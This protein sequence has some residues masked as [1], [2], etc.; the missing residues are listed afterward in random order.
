MYLFLLFTVAFPSLSWA[1]AESLYVRPSATCTNNGD[2]TA[3]ACADS[4]GAA[5]A[6]RGFASVISN[7]IDETAGSLDPGDTLFAC[8][9]FLAADRDTPNYHFFFNVS[10]SY[11]K[12]VTL[13]G[14]CSAVGG[15]ISATLDGETTTLY[16]IGTDA[17]TYLTITH[18]TLT[19]FTARGLLLYNNATTD[20]ML[21]KY[22]TLDRLTIKNIRGASAICSDSRGQHLTFTYVTVTGCGTD[23]I[24]H[25]GADLIVYHATISRI[26]LDA[27]NN[28]D[29]IQLSGILNGALISDSS[30]DMTSMDSK[31][32]L[33]SQPT[34]TG[35]MYFTKNTCVR[36][37]TDTVGSGIRIECPVNMGCYMTC[38]DITGGELGL[39]LINAGG[40]I[41]AAGNLIRGN[42]HD[43]I[44]SGGTGSGVT[45]IV[46]NICDAFLR[47]GILQSNAS[48]TA[49]IENN[50]VYGG[51]ACIDKQA[52]NTEQYNLLYGCA[53]AVTNN[54]T[55]T[56]IGTGDV[57]TQYGS[58]MPFKS[59]ATGRGLPPAVVPFGVTRGSASRDAATNRAVRP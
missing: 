37:T 39:H 34:D 32:C 8:G 53:N 48:V 43:C 41:L 12:I 27:A 45:F 38:S 16:G 9:S 19:G 47:D 23:G 7:A 58:V 55:P 29:G 54:G 2:G 18:L 4:P 56:T 26:S 17:H 11:G 42:T 59:T 52:A 24:W 40:T 10:G 5:G 33:I 3:Y 22:L 1:T 13:D 28:G 44:S 46:N 35:A 25:N 21:D 50:R 15:S 30:I 6:W 31:Y 36:N 20:V 57:T 49:T 14:D 51:L